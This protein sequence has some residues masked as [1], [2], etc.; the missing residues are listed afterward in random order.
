MVEGGV[1][2]CRRKFRVCV[3]LTV[4]GKGVEIMGGWGSVCM[5]LWLCMWQERDG[6]EGM[7]CVCCGK[8]TLNMEP[9]SDSSEENSEV[10][11]HARSSYVE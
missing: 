3:A 1:G 11:S 5:C 10:V 6:I 8:S 4:S 7:V 9:T 2:R